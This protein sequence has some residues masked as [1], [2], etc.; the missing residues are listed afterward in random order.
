MKLSRSTEY[1]FAALRFIALGR[2]S[3]PVLAAAIAKEH[4]IPRDYLLKVLNSLVRAGI[5]S[6]TRGPQGGYRL[7]RASKAITMLEVIEAVEG[8]LSEPVSFACLSGQDAFSRRLTERLG[9][10]DR[11]MAAAFSNTTLTELIGRDLP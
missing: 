2:R 7:A 4:H 9:K 6:S 11:A 8:P 10:A 5:L 3:R 1:A